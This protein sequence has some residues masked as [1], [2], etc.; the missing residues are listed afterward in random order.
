MTC[1]NTKVIIIRCCTL[2]IRAYL[3]RIFVLAKPATLFSKTS[4]LTNMYEPSEIKATYK[5]DFQDI[6][7]GGATSATG[8]PGEL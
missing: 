6:Q 4:V 8:I 1:A 3:E 7:R 2:S 5:A